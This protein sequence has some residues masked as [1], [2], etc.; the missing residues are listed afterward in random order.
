MTTQI[1]MGVKQFEWTY[2]LAFYLGPAFLLELFIHRI[3][4]TV[5]SVEVLTSTVFLFFVDDRWL[6]DHFLTTFEIF[7]S[8]KWLN[9]IYYRWRWT[10]SIRSGFVEIAIQYLI[11]TFIALNCLIWSYLYCSWFLFFNI[12]FLRT[13]D[14]DAVVERVLIDLDR[15]FDLWQSETI[16]LITRTH[17]IVSWRYTLFPVSF[18]SFFVHIWEPQWAVSAHIQ[19]YQRVW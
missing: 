8:D 5:I 10:R 16:R 13:D 3:L 1:C 6:R 14:I 11:L 7:I 4:L 12:I 2:Q 15:P 17:F 19:R 9:W 18:I